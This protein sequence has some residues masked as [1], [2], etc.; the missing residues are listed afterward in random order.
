MKAYS[1]L[2]PFYTNVYCVSLES[3]FKDG[4]DEKLTEKLQDAPNDQEVKDKIIGTVNGKLSAAD[5]TSGVLSQPVTL[6]N[7]VGF[8]LAGGRYVP[9]APLGHTGGDIWI[10]HDGI[11]LGASVAVRG[12]D[13]TRFPH[14]ARP[15][16]VSDVVTE[17]H[18]RTRGDGRDFDI[19]LMLNG[20][21][22]NQLLRALTAG[23]RAPNPTGQMVDIGILDTYDASGNY[24]VHPSVAPLYLPT[25]PAGWFGS[26]GPASVNLYVPSLRV[27][28]PKAGGAS[29]ASDLRTGIEG[30]TDA[31]TLVPYLTRADVATAVPAPRPVEEP[32]DR[33]RSRSGRS[34]SSVPRCHRR[35]R[36]GS[37][38]STPT[39]STSSAVRRCTCAT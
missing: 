6:P 13:G 18:R 34:E 5:L 27:T 12:Q 20:A 1:P 36:P 26:S 38:P 21:S 25:T 4:M 28:L 16:A 22:V 9:T 30:F 17:A 10:H 24:E 39:R 2:P 15:S 31:N 32:D 23:K 29:F 8:T 19:G 11:D 3:D 37:A 35:W 14:S 7:G 33:G